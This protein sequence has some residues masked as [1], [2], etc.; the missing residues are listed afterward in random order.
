M[1]IIVQSWT[2]N[3]PPKANFS[4]YFP[5]L[6]VS[7][8]LWDA[9]YISF[10]S[11]KIKKKLL[12]TFLWHIHSLTTHNP[13]QNVKN[14]QTIAKLCSFCCMVPIIVIIN[15]ITSNALDVFDET[16]FRQRFIN[17]IECRKTTHTHT[18]NVKCQWESANRKNHW[19]QQL[20][21]THFNVNI[22]HYI[23]RM[24]TVHNAARINTQSKYMIKCN[25]LS[26]PSSTA[27]WWDAR[28]RK[29]NFADTAM[30]IKTIMCIL[31]I[32]RAHT[33]KHT[34]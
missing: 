28:S 4:H 12:D 29:K 11:A 18:Q 26:F 8:L 24:C 10:T 9:C 1:F 13:Q 27:T 3:S 33:H 21:W 15:I 32:E 2:K 14:A 31:S 23:P 30:F 22:A 19:L 5:I 17:S 6:S 25:T 7:N 34:R 20:N 16:I